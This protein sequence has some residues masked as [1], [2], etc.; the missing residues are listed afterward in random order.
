MI[1][2]VMKKYSIDAIEMDGVDVSIVEHQRRVSS[3][4]LLVGSDDVDAGAV[5]LL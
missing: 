3:K 5:S 4:F 2:M 1:V